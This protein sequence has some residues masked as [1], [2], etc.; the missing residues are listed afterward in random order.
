MDKFFERRKL[1]KLTQEK[2]DNL[3]SHISIK[4]KASYKE[5]S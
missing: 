2:V 4:E 3:N 1:L 5:N